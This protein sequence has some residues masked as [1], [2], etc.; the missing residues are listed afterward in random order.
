MPQ[1]T[2]DLRSVLHPFREKDF[3]RDPSGL[4]RAEDATQ[5]LNAV[6]S[7]IDGQ[8]VLDKN[9][10]PKSTRQQNINIERSNSLFS[11]RSVKSRLKRLGRLTPRSKQDSRSGS[12]VSEEDAKHPAELRKIRNRRIQRELGNEFLYDE[13][14]KSFSTIVSNVNQKERHETVPFLNRFPSIEDINLNGLATPRR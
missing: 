6:V 8:E 11:F 14:A 2:T 13:D 3:L 1:P 10:S 12:S 5:Q 7:D 9:C 4:S